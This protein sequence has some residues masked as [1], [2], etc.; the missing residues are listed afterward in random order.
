MFPERTLEVNNPLYMTAFF[1]WIWPKTW[2]SLNPEG[3][4]RPLSASLLSPDRLWPRTGPCGS[5]TSPNR[6]RAG[7]RAWPGTISEHPAA[8]ERCWW[9]V[10]ISSQLFFLSSSTAVLLNRGFK[11]FVRGGERREKNSISSMKLIMKY[12]V[13]LCSRRFDRHISHPCFCQLWAIVHVA[14]WGRTAAAAAVRNVFSPPFNLKKKKK[15]LP[16]LFFFF[17]RF[18]VFK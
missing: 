2:P 7:T 3:D 17:F 15:E 6:T 9:R 4:D 10:F 12:I 11:T 16:K 14:E 8:P 18:G 5:P 1:N 13:V